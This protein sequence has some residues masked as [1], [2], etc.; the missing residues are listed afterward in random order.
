M[1]GKFNIFPG[2]ACSFLD[3]T[4]Q[5]LLLAND[6]LEVVIGE[7][8]PFL[9]DLAFENV[10]V[11]FDFE[12]VHRCCFC[13]VAL[14]SG[15]SQ[16]RNSFRRVIVAGSTHP[17]WRVV[18]S[19]YAASGTLTVETA[20]VEDGLTSP[21]TIAR[22]LDDSTPA[23][24]VTSP[25]VLG[26]PEALAAIAAAPHALRAPPGAGPQPPP[27]GPPAPQPRRFPRRC[28]AARAAIPGG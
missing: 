12:F 9:F 18:L 27:H 13:L 25:N 26:H 20:P 6:E 1:K 28:D 14:F 11:P 23:L 16:R 7:L 24:L 10:P 3:S 19:T 17:E 22:L 21:A 4:D 5:L 15:V 2:L 8:G